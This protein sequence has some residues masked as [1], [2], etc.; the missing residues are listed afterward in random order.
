MPRHPVTF[1]IW[2]AI[3]SDSPALLAARLVNTSIDRG[4][5]E[6]RR[7]VYGGRVIAA[8]AAMNLAFPAEGSKLK[9]STG[10]TWLLVD[11]LPKR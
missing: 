10:S 5:L 7:P 1:R 4:V 9:G 3:K 2:A 8:S 11:H 6:A